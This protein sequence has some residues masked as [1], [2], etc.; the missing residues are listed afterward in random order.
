MRLLSYMLPQY[1]KVLEKYI[2][3]NLNSRFFIRF[4][5]KENALTAE[6]LSIAQQLLIVFKR[7]NARLLNFDSQGHSQ[8]CSEGSTPSRIHSALIT[9]NYASPPLRADSV[10]ITNDLLLDRLYPNIAPSR[11]SSAN[12]SSDRRF[13]D[14]DDVVSIIISSDQE[15]Q[16][17][18]QDFSTFSDDDKVKI[19]INESNNEIDE[20]FKALEKI[21]LRYNNHNKGSLEGI[22]KSIKR[23]LEYMQFQ[24]NIIQEQLNAFNQNEEMYV[25][26]K[27]YHVD[28]LITVERVMC[29]L[30]FDIK[31]YS[32]K[33]CDRAKKNL[34]SFTGGILSLTT[35]L[36]MEESLNNIAANILTL[37]PDKIGSYKLIR[38]Y[39]NDVMLNLS[40]IK[41]LGNNLSTHLQENI[42]YLNREFKQQYPYEDD[43][44]IVANIVVHKSVATDENASLNTEKY[45]MSRS[46]RIN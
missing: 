5:S 28:L 30:K 40:K 13:K 7:C 15:E 39:Y 19:V 34:L 27:P 33:H 29:I 17:I 45:F 44:D 46:C 38:S 31:L 35:L 6:K 22:L 2:H 18:L 25:F 9:Q 24:D 3:S 42:N 8:D 4:I 32:S 10:D 20:A 1:I 16:A 21:R 14:M 41:N 11:T 37:D 26:S 23:N 12:N 43:L 36:D